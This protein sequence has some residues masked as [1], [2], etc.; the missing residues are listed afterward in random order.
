VQPR[1][2]FPVRAAVPRGPGQKLA[3]AVFPCGLVGITLV[4]TLFAYE[5]I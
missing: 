3:D 4:A 2:R 5:V 1:E